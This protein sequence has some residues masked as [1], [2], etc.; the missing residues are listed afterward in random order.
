ML[1]DVDG[2]ALQRSIERK[3]YSDRESKQLIFFMLTQE[4]RC[5]LGMNLVTYK[6]VHAGD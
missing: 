1:E 4:Q 2:E 6:E 3:H 5:Y